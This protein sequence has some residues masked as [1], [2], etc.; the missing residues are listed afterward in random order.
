MKHLFTTLVPLVVVALSGSS[1]R[2]DKCGKSDRVELPACAH[3]SRFLGTVQGIRIDNKCSYPITVKFDKPGSDV[4]T[5]IPPK[6]TTEQVLK[7]PFKTVVSCCP[8]YNL[9]A[10]PAPP[11][12]PPPSGRPNL[13]LGKP[14][15]QSSTTNGG[16]ASRANDGNTDGNWSKSSVTHTNSTA[17]AWWQVDLGAI[18]KIGEVVLF[19]RT[20]CCADRLSNFEIKVSNDGATWT[21][22][23]ELAGTAPTQSAYPMNANGRYVRV[24]LRGTN[25]LSLA[26]VQV[27]EAAST[28]FA[29]LPCNSK[30]MLRSSK[31][32]Y[33]HRPD[34]GDLTTWGNGAASP[35]NVW[36]LEC[37]APDKVY[38]KAWTNHYLHRP[39]NVNPIAMTW[40]VRQPWTIERN[41]G[42]VRLKSW[43]N[44]HL[45][46]SS[47]ER[48]VQTGSVDIDWT[49]EAVP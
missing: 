27:F 10:D 48:G 13:A 42:F 15:S 18:K 22:V 5:D 9:C 49:L 44:D 14:A 26:E 31:G 41:G 45:E 35:G 11:P 25:N 24:Q 37:E 21:K 32:D 38:L 40:D 33:L 12:Q 34:G 20:D 46:R 2:A 1:A 17:Q 36:L 8:R 3:F 4:R 6:G 16:N 19:N 7:D 30:V 39:D 47:A 43:K 28:A 23:A 29:G